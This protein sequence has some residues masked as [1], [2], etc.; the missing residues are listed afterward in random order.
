MEFMILHARVSWHL[1]RA[2]EGQG[3]QNIPETGVGTGAGFGAIGAMVGALCHEDHTL[4]QS[5]GV[6]SPSLTS[7]PFSASRTELHLHQ[8]ADSSSFGL[9][10]WPKVRRRSS[11]GV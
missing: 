3:V 6:G 11:W 9:G 8:L 7:S 10:V 1:G 5:S 2:M 4:C